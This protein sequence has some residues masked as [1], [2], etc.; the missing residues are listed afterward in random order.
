MTCHRFGFSWADRLP[1]S[2]GVERLSPDVSILKGYLPDVSVLDVSFPR[3]LCPTFLSSTFHFPDV[4]ARRFISPT[5]VPDVSV[6]DVS[7]PR[8]LCPPF[9]FP[10]VCARR[11]G[12]PHF[13]QASA[14]EQIQSSDKSEHS[15]GTVRTLECD[16]LSSLWIFLG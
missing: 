9:H 6:L 14:P 10:D 4:C 15:I 1:M 5:F 3:R 16:D 11:F 7:F 12:L 2:F 8:R 13:F